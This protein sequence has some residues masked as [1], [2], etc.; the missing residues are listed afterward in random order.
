MRESPLQLVNIALSV[1]IEHIEKKVK[2]SNVF[3][4]INVDAVQRSKTQPY[5]KIMSTGIWTLYTF[6][7]FCR[8]MRFYTYMSFKLF[9]L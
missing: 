6:N 7:N 3:V 5:I 1:G 9:C 2:F 8:P 4:S